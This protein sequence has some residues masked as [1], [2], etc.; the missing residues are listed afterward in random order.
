MSLKNIQHISVYCIR[1]GLIDVL[2]RGKQCR[3]FWPIGWRA[4]VKSGCAVRSTWRAC[5]DCR[6][7]PL[8]PGR[9]PGGSSLSPHWQDENS[10]NCTWIKLKKNTLLCTS[11]QARRQIEYID[12]YLPTSNLKSI[13]LGAQAICNRKRHYVF[14]CYLSWKKTSSSTKPNVSW[15]LLT[16]PVKTRCFWG[17]ACGWWLERGVG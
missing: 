14:K 9:P 6:L 17:W 12:S 7:L 5:W 1:S 8:G 10:K 16:T 2:W 11:N 15:S 13:L 4:E 3:A